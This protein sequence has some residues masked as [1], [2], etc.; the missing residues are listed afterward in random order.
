MPSRVLRAACLILTLIALAGCRGRH[1]RTEVHNEEPAPGSTLSAFVRMSDPAAPAQLTKGF[2]GLEGGAWRWTAGTFQAALRPPLTTEKGALLVFSFSI[3]EVVIQKL[4]SFTLTA[5][6]GS[7]KLK[8]EKYSK[9]GDF[10]FSADVPAA[11]LTGDKVLVD[12]AMDKSLAAG[13]VDQRELGLVATAVG[14]ES[15]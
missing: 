1:S 7:T 2:Y 12:F 8:S 14:F 13:T 11:L 9:P 3:P 10:T 6:I 4:S 15:K 5:S